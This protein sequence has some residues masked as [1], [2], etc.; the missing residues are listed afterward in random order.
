[1]VGEYNNDVSDSD[2]EC[3]GRLEAMG[4]AAA[5]AAAVEETACPWYMAVAVR[6]CPPCAAFMGD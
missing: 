1:M 3:F 2:R 6:R 5:R 4:E